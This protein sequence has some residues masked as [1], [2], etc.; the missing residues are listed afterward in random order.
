MHVVD[1]WR[2]L[3]GDEVERLDALEWEGGA[4]AP[5]GSAH[6]LAGRT[7]GGTLLS[8]TFSQATSIA[9][10]VE[11]IG[12]RGRLTAS[13]YRGDGLRRAPVG[14]PPGGAGPRAREAL[15]TAR[16]LPRQAAAA[17]RGG[18]CVASYAAQWEGSPPEWRERAAPPA[19]R[20]S[21]TGAPRSPPSSPAPRGA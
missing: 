15:R 9:L 4:A 11:L 6:V 1:L 5:P 16:D 17:R 7:A 18:D 2:H 12:D 14:T 21:P 8:A 10:D 13:L 20:R 3:L 19:R